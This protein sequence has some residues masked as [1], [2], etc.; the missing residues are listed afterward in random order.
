MLPLNID[1]LFLRYMVMVDGVDCCPL[2]VKQPF[3]GQG[4]ATVNTCIIPAEHATVVWVTV[5]D[6]L[7][8]ETWMAEETDKSLQVACT[9]L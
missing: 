5:P 2:S 6:N 9:L 7:E 3:F 1:L 4:G 8:H